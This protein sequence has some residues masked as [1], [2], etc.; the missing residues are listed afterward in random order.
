MLACVALPLPHAA[1]WR[2][3]RRILRMLA[4]AVGIDIRTVSAGTPPARPC[5]FVCNHASYIDA[6]VLLCALPRPVTFAAKQELAANPVL[7]WALRRFG[8]MF[9]ARSDV[10]A[11]IHAVEAAQASTGDMLFFPEGTLRHMPGLLHFRLGAFATAAATGMPVVPVTLRG[12]RAVLPDGEW[13]P[14]PGVVVVTVGAAILPAKDGERWH[15]AL[16]LAAAA[17]ARMLERC[18]E[19]DAAEVRLEMPAD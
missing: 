17:R 16:R 15:E 9:V 2:A 6:L 8:V 3:L 11:S 18:G 5:V 10:R 1:R 14:H 13:R 7:G 19:P 4:A 12:T